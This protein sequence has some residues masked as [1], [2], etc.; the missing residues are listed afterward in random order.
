MANVKRPWTPIADLPPDLEALRDPQLSALH[1]LWRESAAELEAKDEYKTFLTHLRRRWA[2]ET[3]QIEHLY[4]ITDA[5]TKTLIEKGLDAAF[6]SHEDTANESPV[7]VVSKIKDQHNAIDGLYEFIS[8]ERPLTK[9]YLR[10]LHQTLTAHQDTYDAVDSL[11]QSVR[12][13]LPRGTWRKH[14]CSIN[15]LE[16]CPAEQIESELDQ[17]LEG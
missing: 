17:L 6:L 11:G 14:P 3:G 9:S 5:G 1:S 15:E 13:Q 2:I 4:S 7:E 8:G 10:E 12:A 16:G